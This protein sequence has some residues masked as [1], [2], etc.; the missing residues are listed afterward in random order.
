MIRN[1]HGKL[2]LQRKFMVKF[3]SN[4]QVQ[5]HDNTHLMTLFSQLIR[6]GADYIC[7]SSAFNKGKTLGSNHQYSCH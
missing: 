3:L 4:F 2:S 1:T 5:R 6:Q 7:Q